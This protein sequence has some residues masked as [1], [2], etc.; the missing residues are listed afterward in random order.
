MAL[1]VPNEIENDLWIDQ[2]KGREKQELREAGREGGKEN[3]LFRRGWGKNSG[4]RGGA[5]EVF[6]PL[7]PEVV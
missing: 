6:V 5:Y 7:S 4:S 1:F 3:F 2:R